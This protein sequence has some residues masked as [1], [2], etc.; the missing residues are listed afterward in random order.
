MIKLKAVPKKEKIT[1]KQYTY[2][3]KAMLVN[4]VKKIGLSETFNKHDDVS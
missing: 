2:K 4:D 1:R 3:F